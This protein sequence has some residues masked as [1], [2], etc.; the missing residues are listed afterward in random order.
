MIQSVGAIIKPP[1]PQLGRPRVSKNPLLHS[2]DQEKTASEI[3]F[4]GPFSS[5]YSTVGTIT[6]DQAEEDYRQVLCKISESK[7]DTI[8]VGKKATDI[9]HGPNNSDDVEVV[10]GT[11]AES[12][13]YYSD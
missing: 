10:A 7:K 3:G 13:S 4:V 6:L 11:P 5:L 12:S 9:P 8:V 2:K 1:L